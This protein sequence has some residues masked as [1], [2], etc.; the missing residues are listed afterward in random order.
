LTG[1]SSFWVLQRETQAL[2]PPA[3][4]A[5]ADDRSACAPKEQGWQRKKAGKEEV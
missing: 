1:F 3:L 5:I 4:Q 2:A